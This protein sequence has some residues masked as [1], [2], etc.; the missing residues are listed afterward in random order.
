M[1][2]KER[3]SDAGKRRIAGTMDPLSTFKKIQEVVA[4]GVGVAEGMETVLAFCE[5][6]R[7]HADWSVLS[8]LP[9]GNLSELRSWLV[10]VFEHEPPP[11]KIVG[12]WFGLFNPVV[13]GVVVCDL[14]LCG[15]ERFS[16]DP[17]DKSWAVGPEWRPTERNAGSR[18]LTAL[19]LVA[20]RDGG[21]G[22]D[23][24]Y[25]L[26]LAYAALAV[27]EVLRAETSFPRLKETVGV[28]VGFD[29]GDFLTLGSLGEA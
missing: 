17:G 8:K 21:L 15:S 14:H 19:Y 2:D 3:M 7:P 16:A 11:Q 18:I 12:L 6:A 9:Y 20:H 5:K 10:R 27:S 1:A 23:A 22:N 29:S 28:A 4:S 26:A 24:E 13:D 25:A